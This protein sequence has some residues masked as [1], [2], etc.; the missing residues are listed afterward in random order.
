M[1]KVKFHKSALFLSTVCIACGTTYVIE[2]VEAILLDSDKRI[3]NICKECIKMGS[4]E[5]PMIIKQQSQMLREKAK[6]LEELSNHSIDCPPWDEY[7]H[8][9]EDKDFKSKT[10]CQEVKAKPQMIMLRVFVV[11][12]GIVPREELEGL[13]SEH[14]KIFL[15]ELD[16]SQWPPEILHLKK[17]AEMEIDEKYLF[18]FDEGI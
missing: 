1:F 3:G 14:I 2:K 6:V 13:Q 12:E 8:V 5:L 17:Y 15:T 18:R 7:L 10:A 11:G 16:I 9:L 4:Q